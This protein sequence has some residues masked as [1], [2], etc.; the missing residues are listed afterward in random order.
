MLPIR[1]ITDMG[2]GFLS[3]VSLTHTHKHTH[4]VLLYP[5]PTQPTCTPSVGG[6]LDGGSG[7]EENDG[8]MGGEVLSIRGAVVLS[9]WHIK[10]YKGNHL[11]ATPYY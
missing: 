6:R 10:L 5:T 1:I 9:V 11:C 2:G 8:R 4:R 7:K 3:C